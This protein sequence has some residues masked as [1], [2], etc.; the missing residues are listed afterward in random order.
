M[1]IETLVIYKEL[2]EFCPYENVFKR[3]LT[4]YFCQQKTTLAHLTIRE[5]SKCIFLKLSLKSSFTYLNSQL[6]PHEGINLK[7]FLKK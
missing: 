5:I 2:E 4:V 6:I 7:S 3:P 1:S